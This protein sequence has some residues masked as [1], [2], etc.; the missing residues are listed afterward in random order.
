MTSI[1]TG[2]RDYFFPKPLVVD[3]PEPE[4]KVF[5]VAYEVINEIGRYISVMTI[6]AHTIMYIPLLRCVFICV[7]FFLPKANNLFDLLSLFLAVYSV[8]TSVFWA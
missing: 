1:V 2:V 3:P 4:K 5:S 7:S 8:V 6:A